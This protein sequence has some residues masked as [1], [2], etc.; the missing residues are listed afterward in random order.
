MQRWYPENERFRYSELTRLIHP[1]SGIYQP[2]CLL[3]LQQ[4]VLSELAAGAG[5]SAR[6]KGVARRRVW[7]IGKVGLPI[8]AGR[9][10]AD[11]GRR[12]PRRL[13]RLLSGPTGSS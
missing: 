4:A 10:V 2:G 7:G 3:D 8:V 9:H 13:G 5:G 1:P 11:S 12:L 6:P